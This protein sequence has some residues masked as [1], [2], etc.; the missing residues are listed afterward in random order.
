MRY[1]TAA[2]PEAEHEPGS[3]GRVLRNKLGIKS[4]LAMDEAEALALERVQR[5]YFTGERISKDTGFTADLL[6]QMH[7][8]WLGAIYE[9]AGCYRTVD[10]SRGGFQFPPAYLIAEN[11]QRFET[12]FLAVYTPCRPGPVREVCEAVA[13]V[14]AELL[15][16][17]PFREG[18]GRLAR[19]LANMMFV[20]ADMT[21]PDYGFVGRGSRRRRGAY[22]DAVI[23][24]YCQDY[25]DLTIFFERALQRGYAAD[26]SLASERGEAPS[27]ADDS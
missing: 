13:R 19:W 25:S 16:I 26:L 14:H 7:S 4:K 5:Q 17:H 22:L 27:N 8:D 20:Q 2:G 15:L 23:K 1:T 24:G 10:M 18:N 11:M 9:W 3:R 6:K 12:G 21:I